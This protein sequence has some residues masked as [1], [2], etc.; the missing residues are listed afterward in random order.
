LGAGAAGDRCR[1]F[2]WDSQSVKAG[3]RGRTHDEATAQTRNDGIFDDFLHYPG[4]LYFAGTGTA[5]V[6]A[7]W[8]DVGADLC[9]GRGRGV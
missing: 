7:R 1:Y 9:H 4:H 8:L 2:S 5:D 6:F 3:T